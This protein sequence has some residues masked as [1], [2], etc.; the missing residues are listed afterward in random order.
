MEIEIVDQEWASLYNRH[1][2]SE[3]PTVGQF[4]VA[5]GL[6]IKSVSTANNKRSLHL[7]KCRQRLVSIV[8]WILFPFPTLTFCMPFNFLLP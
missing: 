1:V 7:S 2:V 8:T 4:H 6:T 3:H 5:V